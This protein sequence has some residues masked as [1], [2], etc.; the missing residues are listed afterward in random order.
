MQFPK[1]DCYCERLTIRMCANVHDAGCVRIA[2]HLIVFLL[3]HVRKF[4]ILE[5]FFLISTQ[6]LHAF[7][8]KVTGQ[9]SIELFATKNKVVYVSPTMHVSNKLLLEL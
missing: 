7:S 1:V 3:H 8:A 2:F 4:N 6:R 5:V 9:S